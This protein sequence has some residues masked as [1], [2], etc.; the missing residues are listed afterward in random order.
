DGGGVRIA[1]V[2]Q[3][4]LGTRDS[5]KAERVATGQRA[6]FVGA[7]DVV[8][9]GCN[10]RR[11]GRFWP[12]RTKGIKRRHGAQIMSRPMD[13]LKAES[14]QLSA[15][16]HQLKTRECVFEPAETQAIEDAA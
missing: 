3:L 8:G 1:A 9:N 10:L 5:E 6:R 2:R 4:E 16:R 15:V 13:T 12:Q 14:R 7:D 11:V